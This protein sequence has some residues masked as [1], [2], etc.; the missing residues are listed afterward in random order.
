VLAT[1]WCE[2]IV[3]R[4]PDFVDATDQPTAIFKDLKPI[5]QTFGRRYEIISFRWLTP[6][7]V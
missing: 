4:V 5:N 7:E 3:Q 2:A 6:S 1:A